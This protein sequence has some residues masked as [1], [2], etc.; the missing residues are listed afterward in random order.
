MSL[1]N[2]SMDFQDDLGLSTTF[3][4]EFHRDWAPYTKVP[5]QLCCIVFP[6]V[7]QQEGRPKSHAK[8]GVVRIP[9]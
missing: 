6:A 9:E 7:K 4:A 5:G 2:P 8:T 3:N 1:Q